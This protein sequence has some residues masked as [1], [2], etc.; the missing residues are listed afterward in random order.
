MNALVHFSPVWWLWK[1]PVSTLQPSSCSSPKVVKISPSSSEDDEPGESGSAS[2][3]TGAVEASVDSLGRRCELLS[4]PLDELPELPAELAL[5]PVPEV[6]LEL[7]LDAA[8]AVFTPRLLFPSR[9][10]PSCPAAG[11]NAA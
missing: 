4:F 10:P 2:T 8:E 6:E 9:P 7:D 1:S 5:A 11:L 3:V